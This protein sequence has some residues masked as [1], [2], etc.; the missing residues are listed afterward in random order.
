MSIWKEEYLRYK[1]F[2]GTLFCVEALLDLLR[3][4]NMLPVVDG[5][6]TVY[7]FWQMISWI[8]IIGL[9]FFDF[10][11]FFY[12]GRDRL[13]HLLPIGKNRILYMKSVVYGIYMMLYFTVGLIRYLVLL[14]QGAANSIG[15][16]AFLYMISKL[17]AILSFFSL[18]IVILMMIKKVNN[19]MLGA[20]I[21]AILFGV[22]VS[23][24]A[25]GLFHMVSLSHD[26]SWTIGIVDGAI[27]INQY[28]NILPIVFIQQG[29]TVG[30]VEE[31]FYDVSLFLNVGVII[32]SFIISTV[33]YK[34]QK[35]NYIES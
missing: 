25:Y 34:T 35:F 22:I 16:V 29:N 28:A 7:S 33:L 18:L 32:L 2:F 24:Q 8:F 11:S 19:K 20:V 10:F 26:V 5:V 12:L 6:D 23:L 17:I 27:G 15:K 21:M 4:L 14:P 1:Y 31:N 30:Y 13:L 9:I 3:L